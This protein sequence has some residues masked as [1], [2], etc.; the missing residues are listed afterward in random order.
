MATNP[1]PAPPRDRR[2]LYVQKGSFCQMFSDASTL[3]TVNSSALSHDHFVG[4]THFVIMQTI[5]QTFICVEFTVGP[6]VKVTVRARSP[7]DELA[8][9]SHPSH[10]RLGVQ[11]TG[12]AASFTFDQH[13]PVLQL[14]DC[15]TGLYHLHHLVHGSD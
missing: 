1:V 8:S 3:H 15:S 9:P 12:S 6:T 11:R 5:M 14:Q 13:R 2:I 10:Q 4:N 7:T